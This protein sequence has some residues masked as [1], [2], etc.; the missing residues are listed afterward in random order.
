M[1]EQEIK[2]L[3][4]RLAREVERYA[5]RDDYI[6]G[7]WVKIGETNALA[8]TSEAEMLVFDIAPEQVASL[9]TAYAG[10][11]VLEDLIV[12]SLFD[13]RTTELIE[14]ARDLVPPLKSFGRNIPFAT[15]MMDERFFA[16]FAREFFGISRRQAYAIYAKHDFNVHASVVFSDE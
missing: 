10:Y 9:Q 14:K 4:L 12:P 15:G 8:L 3:R 1:T 6:T 5:E 7:A 16:W 11:L 13:D 2:E